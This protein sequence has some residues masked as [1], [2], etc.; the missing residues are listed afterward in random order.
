MLFKSGERSV[1][2]YGFAKN[3]RDNISPSELAAFKKLAD[4]YLNLDDAFID[5]LLVEGKLTEIVDHAEAEDDDEE[6]DEEHE[7]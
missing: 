2:A 1:F 5:R 7:D 3:Q 4:K 6:N